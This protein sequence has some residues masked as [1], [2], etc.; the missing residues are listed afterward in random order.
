[1][2]AKPPGARIL[3]QRRIPYG[4]VPFDPAIRDAVEVAA[5]AGHPAA[6]VYKT[7]V[8]EEEPTRGKPMLVMV[9]ADHELDLKAF[10]SVVGVKKARMASHADAERLTGLRVGGISAIALAGRGFR[11]YIDEAALAL[12]TVL[13]SAG[14]RGFDV[15]LR[16]RDLVAVTGAR[17]VGGCTRPLTGLP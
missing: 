16:T 4:L 11:V 9:P 6:S 8:V 3:D 17:A 15:A 1:M 10:A 7:L 5:A 13:V 2:A 14:Q 12:E